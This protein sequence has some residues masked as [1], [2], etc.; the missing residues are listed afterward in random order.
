MTRH[1]TKDTQRIIWGMTCHT[2]QP[3][4]YAACAQ[5]PQGQMGLLHVNV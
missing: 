1:V 3:T 2:I 5:E 4:S